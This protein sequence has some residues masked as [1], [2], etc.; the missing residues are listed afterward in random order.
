M[1]MSQSYG[2]ADEAESTAT[3]H[4]ALELGVAVGRP[5][6]VWRRLRFVTDQ[7]RAWSEAT[8]GNPRS[9]R[10]TRGRNA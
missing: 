1:G 8:G 4:R 10:A 2:P 6:D 7:A 9:A 5:R 3:I